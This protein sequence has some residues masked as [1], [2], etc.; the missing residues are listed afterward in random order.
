MSHPFSNLERL[1]CSFHISTSARTTHVSKNTELTAETYQSSVQPGTCKY[2]LCAFSS[3]VALQRDM[4][5][6]RT[7]CSRGQTSLCRSLFCKHGTQPPPLTHANMHY[8]WPIH[9]GKWL[10]NG[11]PISIQQQTISYEWFFSKIVQNHPPCTIYVPDKL[12][13]NCF[14]NHCFNE[15]VRH[16]ITRQCLSDKL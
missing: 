5:L 8:N 6:Q 2:F 10:L 4:E 9:A 13:W 11:L 1:I 15:T 7:S 12:I 3:H 14:I 16:C